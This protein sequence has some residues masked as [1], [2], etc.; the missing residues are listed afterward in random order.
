VNLGNPSFAVEPNN[1][2]Q[3]QGRI[4]SFLNFSTDFSNNLSNDKYFMSAP[5]NGRLRATLAW[6]ST[7]TGCNSSNGSGCQGDQLDAD[8]DLRVSQFVNGQWVEVCRSDTFDSSWE[9]CDMN[10]PAGS[11]FK[12][13][14]ILNTT[15][16][17]GTDFG[18]AWSFYQTSAE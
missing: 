8:L 1:P 4:G 2:A 16:Q 12:A 10:A 17:S 18:F 5:N 13:D 9:M 14:F 15:T 7:V 6:D 11:Q 3:P